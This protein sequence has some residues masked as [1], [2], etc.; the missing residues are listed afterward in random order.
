MKKSIL[1]LSTIVILAF[2]CK[3]DKGDNPKVDVDKSALLINYA[4]NLIMPA[5][6]DLNTKVTILE[7]KFDELKAE[8]S[9]SK[10]DDLKL[11]FNNLRLSWQHCSPYGFGPAEQILLRQSINTFPTDTNR[12]NSNIETGDYSF[13]TSTNFKAKGLPALDYLLYK[14][15]NAEETFTDSLKLNYIKNIILDIKSIV[16]FVNEEWK[17]YREVFISKTGND[18]GS[19]LSLLVNEYI[20]DYEIAKNAKMA[21]PLGLRS[22]D[23]LPYNF[24][25][26]Y[27]QNSAALLI[28]NLEAL[29][30]VLIGPD[31]SEPNKTDNL[32]KYLNRLSSSRDDWQLSDLIAKEFSESIYMLKLVTLPYVEAVT[33]NTEKAKLETAYQNMQRTTVL[34]KNDMTSAMGIRITYQDNDGD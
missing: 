5:F 9:E 21:I 32:H 8:Y 10:L 3:E 27:S 14:Y 7:E 25:A 17:L 18:V 4:D 24:E 34:L 1:L 15:D 28:E 16:E 26:P 19:S 23:I 11:A 22:T 30:K 2:G 6:D 33:I 13:A 12:I 20:F 29:Q 31:F